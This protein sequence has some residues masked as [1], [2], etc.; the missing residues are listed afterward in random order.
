MVIARVFQGDILAFLFIIV[1]D[2]ALQK[3]NDNR[4]QIHSAGLLPDLD[5]A[6]NIMLLDQYKTETIE[7][8]QRIGCSAEKVGLN[9]FV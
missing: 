2:F 9:K 8:F 5:F 6:K 7:Y 3:T 4:L 1:L